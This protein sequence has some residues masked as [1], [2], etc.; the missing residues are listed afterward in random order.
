MTDYRGTLVTETI[1]G[2]E[3]TSEKFPATK[4]LVL[5]GR[6]TKA[7]GEHGVKSVVALKAQAMAEIAPW[8]IESARNPRFFAAVVQL[9]YGVVEDENLPRDLCALLH[10]KTVRPTGAPGK[11]DG[12]MFD[13]HFTGELPHLG[14]VLAF[15][16]A[17][18]YTGF[19][20]GLPSP[21][22]SPTSKKT[23]PDDLSS[24]PTPSA[25]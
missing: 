20:L 3:Y 18:T 15:V 2:L 24:S 9:A 19:T 25:E 1:D 7:L 8:L 11:I 6:L 23:T 13:T 12:A 16:L 17:H 22:G 21:T 5:L 4:S 10:C 14:K